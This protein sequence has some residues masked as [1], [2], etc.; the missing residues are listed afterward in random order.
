MSRTSGASLVPEGV[1]VSTR[2]RFARNVRGRAFPG[3]LDAGE[4][5]AV[6]TQL[7]RATRRLPIECG[8]PYA[9]HDLE[10]DGLAEVARVARD[11]WMP[12]PGDG[13][14]A[15]RWL[16]RDHRGIVS[17]LVNDEDH[18]RVQAGG[19]GWCPDRLVEA[20][21]P[22]ADALE[23]EVGFATDPRWGY[24]TASPGNLGSGFRVSALVHLPALAWS[25]EL[26]AMVE[27]ARTLDTA[28]RGIDGEGSAVSG[29]LLQVSNAVA[30]GRPLGG[31][32]DRVAALVDRLVEAEGTALERLRRSESAS[33]GS[34][35]ERERIGLVSSR[36]MGRREALDFLSV[37][38]LAGLVGAIEREDERRFGE[39]V[40]EVLADRT[41]DAELRAAWLRSRMWIDPSGAVPPPLR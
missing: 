18:A 1:V 3:A 27:A 23:Q 13:D 32:V 20:A 12:V 9:V 26:P 22:V 14:M 29:D 5:A 30:F 7:R 36:R 35:L 17:I 21:L 4:R 10:H 16:F 33:I 6:A 34:R 25:G 15:G 8:A 19:D 38:R 39:S 41:T 11:R 2:V 31:I 24:L 40:R 28:V 37:R